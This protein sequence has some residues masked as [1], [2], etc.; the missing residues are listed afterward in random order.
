MVSRSFI[1]YIGITLV[2]AVTFFFIVYILP[3]LHPLV[4]IIIL[5]G[6]LILMSFGYTLRIRRLRMV[7]K[8]SLVNNQNQTD[9]T[10]QEYIQQVE[11]LMGKK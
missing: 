6:M 4:G 8:E 5:S 3:S 2:A 1:Y 7:S 10:T 11:R 9:M